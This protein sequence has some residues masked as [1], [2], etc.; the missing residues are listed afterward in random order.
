M[1]TSRDI[2][3]GVT[4]SCIF[5]YARFHGKVVH[6]LVHANPTT[7]ARGSGRAHGLLPI[8]HLAAK[9]TAKPMRDG[10]WG[11]PRFFPH[12]V[13]V[14]MGCFFPMTHSMG[15]LYMGWSMANPTTK[16]VGAREPMGLP[17]GHA[18]A[19]KN[20]IKAHRHSPPMVYPGYPMGSAMGCSVGKPVGGPIGTRIF[21]G[22][23][24]GLPYGLPEGTPQDCPWL[25]PSD[26]PIVAYARPC[27][28]TSGHGIYVCPERP[29]VWVCM[30]M[31]RDWFVLSTTLLL[32]VMI[33]AGV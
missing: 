26:R 9:P 27:Y 6:G 18:S 21:H 19:N 10:P 25:T 2:S 14:C 1:G 30:M 24:H 32:G 12:M 13:Y 15:M 7:K 11:N 31:V 8:G 33:P 17:I 28:S 22:L 16:P 4:M 5:P 23:S 3:H 29:V 20:T